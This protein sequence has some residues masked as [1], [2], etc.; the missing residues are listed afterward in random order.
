MKTSSENSLSR[1]KTI[2][3]VVKVA[4]ALGR[5][6]EHAVVGSSSRT[7]GWHTPVEQ[8]ATHACLSQ[9]IIRN[10]SKAGE[11]HLTFK[12]FTNKMMKTIKIKKRSLVSESSDRGM[13]L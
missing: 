1:T 4:C 7:H 3:A 5:S 9:F 11:E 6:A 10:K 13:T 2:S 12:A 8:P